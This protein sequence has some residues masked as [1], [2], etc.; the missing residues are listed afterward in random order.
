MTLSV[1]DSLWWPWLRYGSHVT[2][3][4]YGASQ[5]EHSELGEPWD[6][7]VLSALGESWWKENIQFSKPGVKRTC[8]R[9]GQSIHILR[10]AG[11]MVSVPTMNCVTVSTE[12]PDTVCAQ[13]G[14]ARLQYTLSIY[15]H[16][17]LNFIQFSCATKCRSSLDFFQPFKDVKTILSCRPYQRRQG[18]GRFGKRFLVCQP[19]L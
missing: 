7:E 16:G 14:T 17:N 10:F 8:S 18:G 15:G 12:R 6:T 11:R 9:K 13:T 2:V 3:T 1:R 4:G 5:I 19:L